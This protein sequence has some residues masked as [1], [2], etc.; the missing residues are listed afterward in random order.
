[1]ASLGYL[2]TVKAPSK[3]KRLYAQQ[4]GK[5]HYCGNPVPYHRIT[6]DH[7]VRRRHGGTNHISNLVLAC[8]PC[9]QYREME[10]AAPE[11]KQRFLRRMTHYIH[12]GY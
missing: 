6:F 1:V 4:K 11:V 5:C 9:N 10:D 3:K 8:Q 12:T 7:I 2:C